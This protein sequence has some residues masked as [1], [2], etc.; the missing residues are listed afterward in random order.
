MRITKAWLRQAKQRITWRVG[1]VTSIFEVGGVEAL[2]REY[3]TLYPHADIP[4]PLSARELMKRL[5]NLYIEQV[6]PS[7]I[8]D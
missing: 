3:V 6:M 1:E 5:I 4:N 7:S 2:R 8:T